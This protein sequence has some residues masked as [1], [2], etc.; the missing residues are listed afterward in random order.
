MNVGMFDLVFTHFLILWIVYNV[1]WLE[2]GKQNYRCETLSPVPKQ[3][4]RR[5]NLTRKGMY[6][7]PE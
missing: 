1:Q 3:I 5:Q 6:H 2:S 7:I 4:Y